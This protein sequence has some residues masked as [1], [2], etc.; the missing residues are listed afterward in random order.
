[1]PFKLDRSSVQHGP[2]SS[3][4]PLNKNMSLVD[5]LVILFTGTTVPVVPTARISAKF[6]SSPYLRMRRSVLQL[7]SLATSQTESDVTLSIT[8]FGYGTTTIWR[9]RRSPSASCCRDGAGS[10]SPTHSPSRCAARVARSSA[11][12]SRPGPLRRDAVAVLED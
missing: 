6:G 2:A 8:R 10:Y 11:H 1:M 3:A 5:F 9:T 4:P 7:E 12:L